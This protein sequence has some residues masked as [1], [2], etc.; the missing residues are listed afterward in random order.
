MVLAHWDAGTLTDDLRKLALPENHGFPGRAAASHSKN[1][2]DHQPFQF[3]DWLNRMVKDD[4][5]RRQLGM[6]QV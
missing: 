6:L 4:S 3:W 2:D 1:V 5:P